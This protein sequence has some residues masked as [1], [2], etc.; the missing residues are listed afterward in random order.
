MTTEAART[1][2]S[3]SKRLNLTV[4]YACKATELPLRAQIR[5]WVRAGIDLVC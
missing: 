1:E 5:A 3:P 2:K 4:Q